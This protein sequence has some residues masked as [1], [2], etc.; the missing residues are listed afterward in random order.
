MAA[1]TPPGFLQNAGN[2]HTAEITRD[3]FS[4]TIALPRSGG[5]LVPR[6]GVVP[7]LGGV[8]AV[9]QNGT[10]NMSVNVAS[11]HIYVPG[12]ESG[13]QGVYSCL[14]DA[15]LNVTI[16][17]ADPSQPRIDIIVA[18]IRDAFYSGASND[19]RIVAV[20]GTPAGS[21]SAPA[22]PANSLVI[23][24]IAVAAGVT[25]IVNANITDN[26]YYLT[27][28]GGQTFCTSATRPPLVGL[29]HRIYESD[30]GLFRYWSG[31]EWRLNM[32]YRTFTELSGTT[33]SVTFNIPSTLRT[34]RCSWTARGNTAAVALQMWL[35][36]NGNTGANY[37]TGYS[38]IFAGALSAISAFSSDRMQCGVLAG[39]SATAGLYSS[40]EFVLSG[41]DA[42]H[43]NYLGMVFNSQFLQSSG[44]YFIWTGGGNYSQAGPY[45]SFTLLP[46]SGSF[47]ADCQFVV[48]AWD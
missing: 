24:T 39:A 7:D 11:G 34:V 14:N 9:T 17:A 23:A 25:S 1:V 15:T 19:F 31:S 41:W 2:V 35:R 13:K 45:T 42:P 29:G 32:P 4:S 12:T 38:Q 46:E 47:I 36:I 22:T 26:R 44:Q 20:T 18:Q 8:L 3:A 6:G 28:V 10:P 30:T 5:S 21:P 48:E 40:G 43:T 37:N 27:T 16:A 33:A